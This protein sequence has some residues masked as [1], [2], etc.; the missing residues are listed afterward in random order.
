MDVLR[1]GK[2]ET[3]V[4][5]LRKIKRRLVLRLREIECRWILGLRELKSTWVLRKLRKC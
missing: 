4:L 5:R 3:I 1:L 2:A